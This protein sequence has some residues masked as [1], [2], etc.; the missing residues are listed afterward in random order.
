MS[1][2]V[3]YLNVRS[4]RSNQNQGCFLNDDRL[5][6]LDVIVANETWIKEPKHL[7]PPPD[8]YDK[9]FSPNFKRKWGVGPNKNKPSLK[10]KFNFF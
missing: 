7:I 2:H 4:L 9:F 10:E 3:G 1:I 6:D 5:R 8:G